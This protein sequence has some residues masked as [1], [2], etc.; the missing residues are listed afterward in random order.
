V[1]VDL[2]RYLAHSLARSPS[3]PSGH[4]ADLPE[5]DELL[6]TRKLLQRGILLDIDPVI[7]HL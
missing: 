7:S 6:R 4:L 5:G 2:I 3:T 1:T